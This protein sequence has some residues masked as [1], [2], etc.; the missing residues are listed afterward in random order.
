MS[1]VM[2]TFMLFKSPRLCLVQFAQP[3]EAA[4][5]LL[6]ALVID[7]E[8]MVSRKNSPLFTTL[9]EGAHSMA[10]QLMTPNLLEET[11]LELAVGLPATVLPTLTEECVQQKVPA[12]VAVKRIYLMIERA[13][14]CLRAADQAELVPPLCHWILPTLYSTEETECL[15]QVN[16]ILRD[17]HDAINEAAVSPRCRICNFCFKSRQIFD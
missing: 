13:V 9:S 1:F 12:S 17:S 14:K 3:A 11:A 16:E 10:R 5:S 2:E 8:Q 15:A 7:I 4:Q 6:H